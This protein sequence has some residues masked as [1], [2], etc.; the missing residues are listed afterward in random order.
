MYTKENKIF[1]FLNFKWLSLALILFFSIS[2][3]P[4]LGYTT[5]NN[6]LDKSIENYYYSDIFLDI[7]TYEDEGPFYFW[8]NF[9]SRQLFSNFI[10]N[11]DDLNKFYSNPDL[12]F[13]LNFYQILFLIFWQTILLILLFWFMTKIFDT[14]KVFIILVAL[15]SEPHFFELTTSLNPYGL[16]I[17]LILNFLVSFYLYLVEESKDY[18][19]I[20][21]ILFSFSILTSSISLLLFPFILVSFLAKYFWF[22][23]FSFKKLCLLVLN[24]IALGFF[25][26]YI[27]WP[28]YWFRPIDLFLKIFN[29]SELFTGKFVIGSIQNYEFSNSFYF[30][31]VAFIKAT[32]YIFPA[33][34]VAAYMQLSTTYRK[35]TFEIYILISSILLLVGF[36]LL[37]NFNFYLISIFLTIVS[38]IIFSYVYDFSQ[39]I[40]IYFIGIN[41]FFIFY[42]NY[43]FSSY[44]NPFFGGIKHSIELVPPTLIFG[45]K[46]IISFFALE[47]KFNEFEDL[48]LNSDLANLNKESNF[49][50]VAVPQNLLFDLK[51]HFNLIGSRLVNNTIYNDSSKANFFVFP[52]YARDTYK[53]ELIEKYNLRYYNSI[54]IRG[55]PVYKVY[56]QDGR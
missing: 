43:D 17:F 24:F 47:K 19:I 48:E 30:L 1:D 31:I 10:F 7:Q 12:V 23:R 15:V 49:L 27:I 11:L 14:I 55:V 9:A 46:E 35:Y 21:N 51:F 34:L 52:I 22:K 2:R 37:N 50:I 18:L 36:S 53:E 33:L 13:S 56:K 32:I 40:L 6:D 28:V 29:F 41:I 38:L 8:I 26:G 16:L 42:L 39:K 4:Y 3:L 44:F 20:S 5:V 54:D 45:E 25:I